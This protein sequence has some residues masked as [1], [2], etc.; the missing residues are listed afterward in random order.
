MATPMSSS[1]SLSISSGVPLVDGSQYRSIVGALQYCTL[2]RPDIAF[3]VNKACQ[4][5]HSPTDVHWLAVKRI[6]RYLSGTI[7]YG[8][9]YQSSA[10]SSVLCYTDADWASCPSDRRNT[11]AFCIFHGLNLVSWSSSK[12]RVVSR[13][14]ME[15]E[16][17]SLA[18]GT[19]ELLWLQALFSDLQ[20]HCLCLLY[21]S[22]TILVFSR[23]S[24]EDGWRFLCKLLDQ[25]VIAKGV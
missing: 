8:L 12:Q 11:N 13:S 22:A 17:R 1:Q 10:D 9:H 20:T 5:M 2:T 21:Y 18:N 4:F 6:L 25:A 16:Y 14:S 15:S 7:D 24:I 3:S 19:A 23:N